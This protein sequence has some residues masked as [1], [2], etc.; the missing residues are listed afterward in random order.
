VSRV[1]IKI[2]LPDSSAT[3]RLGEDLARALKKGDILAL[4]GD[5]GA[6]KSTLARAF[7]RAIAHDGELE[8]P[9][10]TFTLVQSY[11]LRIPVGHFDLYRLNDPSELDELGLDE[12]AARGIAL[13]EWPEQAGNHI[14]A[15]ALKLELSEH[16][17]GRQGAI[18]G[19]KE[20]IERVERT[21]TIRQFLTR[22][23]LAQAH[24]SWFQGDASTRAF[25]R[26]TFAG[27]PDMIL[28]DHPEKPDLSPIVNGR[29]YRQTARITWTV[30]PFVAVARA[31]KAH[32]FAAP[33]M[34]ADDLNAGILLM[35]NLGDGKV[36]DVGGAPIT[37]RYKAAVELLAKLHDTRI[38]RDLPIGNGGSYTLP[39][40]DRE[41]LLVEAR[42]MIEW[43]V[44]Y[45][46]GR[47]A[48]G[49]ESHEFDALWDELISVLEMS[50]TGLI[51]RDY[52]SPNLIWRAERKGTDRLGL[53]DVQ[54]ALYGPLSYDVSSLAQDAR[55]TIPAE[56]EK[57]LLT[58]YCDSRQEYG[59]FDESAF[60]EAYAITALQR[61]TKILG[62]FV[63]LDKRDGKP[64]YLRHLPR[65]EAYV[66]RALAHPKLAKLSRFYSSFLN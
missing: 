16:G 40:Y 55:A 59:L 57:E 54:D 58:A 39:P 24:R 38:A 50:E 53:V 13:V 41:A 65:I 3:E 5:L 12:A 7:I 10:P 66:K 11:D 42:L 34:I 23:G 64:D 30:T 61:A 2:D 9:S 62:I 45:R 52:H 31:L 37:E 60:R 17:E 44:P 28:M 22:H 32:G 18:S 29:S 26:I 36:T 35:E 46:L 63:R 49:E 15:N 8:V 19:P 48:T 14:P 27:R 1:T 6:G 43:Y 33:Q 4:S 20:A 47:E 51:L 56:M 21:L 25:E